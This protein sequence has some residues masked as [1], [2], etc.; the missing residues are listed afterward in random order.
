MWQQSR[1][2]YVYVSFWREAS[3]I[4]QSASL[5]A[6]MFVK[7]ESHKHYSFHFSVSFSLITELD[8]MSQIREIISSDCCCLHSQTGKTVLILYLNGYRSHKHHCIQITLNYFYKVLPHQI[9][10]HHSWNLA[11]VA[12]TKI[13]WMH[14]SL[15]FRLSVRLNLSSKNIPCLSDICSDVDLSSHHT[16]LSDYAPLSHFQETHPISSSS[17]TFLAL[18]F[19]SLCGGL[20]MGR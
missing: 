17:S 13:A 11:P 18:F 5:W 14:H 10:K 20:Y 7:D 3:K 19:L 15:C 9:T 8:Y 12:S 2:G 16:H 1:L 6:C 4:S